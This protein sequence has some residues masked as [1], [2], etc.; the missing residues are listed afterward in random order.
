LKFNDPVVALAHQRI[1]TLSAEIEAQLLDMKHTAPALEILR[2]LRIRA[3]E[4]L[5]ALA[6]LNLDDPTDLMQA[7]VMQNEVKKYDE[8]LGDLKNILLEGLQYDQQ[9]T[10]EERD[11]LLDYLKT[12][13]D[14]RQE[15][16]ELGLL[17]DD[18]GPQHE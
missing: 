10:S 12:T 8:W 1:I 3:A 9:Q 5:A 13:A 4:S 14:G 18:P 11:Q 15:A 7:K 16:M 6:F 2:R 17:D